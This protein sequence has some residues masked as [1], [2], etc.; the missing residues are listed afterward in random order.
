MSFSAIYLSTAISRL[1]YYKD[2]GAKA[3]AQLTDEELNYQPDPES[4]SVAMIVRHLSGNML[5]RWTNFLQE[6][7]EK[8]WRQRDDEFRDSNF[9]REEIIEAWNKGWA[10]FIDA[11]K[12][13]SKK[14]LKK[15]I[16]IRGEGL[17]VVDAI[18]RQ[19]AHYPYHVGQMVFL[20]KMIK[21]QNWKNLSIPKGG[22]AAYNSSDSVKDPAKSFRP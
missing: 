20:S 21:K 4:N 8:P 13:L 2:L 19:L 1:L 5:S 12:D 14:D 15:K 6:D 3:M 9:S 17:T 10:C 16:Y 11:I 22:S 18:N 7:G